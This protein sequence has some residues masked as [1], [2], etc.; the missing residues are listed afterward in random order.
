MHLI[1]D[2]AK[3]YLDI[4]EWEIKGLTL[5][6]R[7]PLMKTVTLQESLPILAVVDR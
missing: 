5:G 1:Q 6:S 7:R 2:A 3:S 4:S